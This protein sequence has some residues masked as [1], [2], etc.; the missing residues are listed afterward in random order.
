MKNKQKLRM[1]LNGWNF[2]S[3]QRT[4][5]TNRVQPSGRVFVDTGK[6]DPQTFAVILYN[7]KV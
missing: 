5:Q 2:S 7:D 4:A 6:D 3:C 1:Q